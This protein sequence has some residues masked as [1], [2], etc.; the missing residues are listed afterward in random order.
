ML[1]ENRES[2]Y[3]AF[4]SKDARFDGRFF[5]GVASTGIYCRPVCRAKL[6]KPENCTYYRTAAEAEQAG[7]R[8]C[9][10]CR[11]EL[12]PGFAPVDAAASMARR[13]AKL[14]EED[15]NND[16]GLAAIADKLGCTDRHLRRVFAE[17]YH[18]SPV[19][20]R[21]TC[22]L[23]LAKS[24]LTDTAL[25]VTDV[26]MASG[27]GSLRRFN[28]LFKKQ[29]R[30][31]P[32]ALRKQL[33]V[34]GGKAGDSIILALGYRPP[35]EW[36]RMLEFLRLRA[37]PGVETV[38][39]GVYSRTVCL[40]AKDGMRLK[41]WIQ[42]ADRPGRNLLSVTVSASLL[43]VL[44]AVLNRVRHLFDLYCEPEAVREALQCMD[45]IK[46]GLFI[47][48]IRV[49][50]CFDAFEMSVRAVLGQQISVKA[51]STLAGRLAGNFGGRADTGIEGLRYIFPSPDRIAALEQ[52]VED[53]LGPLGITGARARTIRALAEMFNGS[54]MDFELCTQPEEE[55]KRLTALPGIGPWTAHYIAMRAL[56]W[57]DAFLETDLGVRKA[58]APRGPREILAL[59]QQWRPWRA[60]ATLCLW[61]Q[62]GE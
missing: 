38:K 30:L 24:L 44:P 49:P 53:R 25:S 7:L 62:E 6:P 36:E 3:A 10:Q 23:L 34:S 37:I 20:Y 41:G 21:Q 17:E 58:L 48:G 32:T 5:V 47:P 33:S 60:Y 54:P 12:A 55:I 29:Y 11:P 18:V 56:G 31:A 40:P 2:L 46:P 35:Y 45:G 16:D 4:K 59:A 22:R 15:C 42:A 50:G 28:D 27:F 52:P 14:I 51:A 61:N 8:P 1:E 39:D 26:A 57:T 13:A 43:P 9:L 19:E